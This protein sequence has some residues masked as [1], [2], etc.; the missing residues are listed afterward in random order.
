MWIVEKMNS[1]MNFFSKALCFIDISSMQTENRARLHTEARPE[2][3]S[4]EQADATQVP[5]VLLLGVMALHSHNCRG[6][7]VETDQCPQNP[8]LLHLLA[9][10]ARA[11][12]QQCPGAADT[13]HTHPGAQTEASQE[14]DILENCI[15]CPL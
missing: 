7:G 4:A 9:C 15:R 1:R 12:Q 2:G 3:P 14:T 11:E 5:T 13:P 10:K 6:G 8:S